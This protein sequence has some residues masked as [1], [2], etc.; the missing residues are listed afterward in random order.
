VQ[1]LPTLPRHGVNTVDAPLQERVKSRKKTIV[2][3]SVIGNPLKVDILLSRAT[4]TDKSISLNPE[5]S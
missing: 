3:I 5:S 1:A 2:F 4:Y